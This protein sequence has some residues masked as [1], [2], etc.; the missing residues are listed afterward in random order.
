MKRD[1]INRL[2]VR[3]KREGRKGEKKRQRNQERERGGKRE[4]DP[5][6]GR[7]GAVMTSKVI[8]DG[9]VSKVSPCVLREGSRILGQS[10]CTSAGT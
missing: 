2:A 3:R 6:R 4:R 10:H 5:T 8:I 9:G 1:L 7:V